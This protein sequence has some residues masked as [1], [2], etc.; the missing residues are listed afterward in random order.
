ML[1]AGQPADRPTVQEHQQ[2]MRPR[3]R[4]QGQQPLQR[5]AFMG[6]GDHLNSGLAGCAK[7][8]QG[9]VAAARPGPDQPRRPVAVSPDRQGVVTAW[10]ERQ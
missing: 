7:Q 9:L 8:L 1:P 10:S 3:R 2:Q 5:R 6:P 4:R